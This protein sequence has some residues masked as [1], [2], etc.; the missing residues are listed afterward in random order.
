MPHVDANYH[1][2]AAS[3]EVNARITQRQQTLA[4]YITLVLGL[5]AAGGLARRWRRGAPGAAGRGAD[6]IS[7]RSH[8]P[9]SPHASPPHATGRSARSPAKSRPRTGSLRA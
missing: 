7:T 8:T 9:S 3:N 4:L 2:I 6:A 1:F 5:I